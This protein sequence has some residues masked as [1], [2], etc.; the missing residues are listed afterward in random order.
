MLTRACLLL[1]AIASS[2]LA[3]PG[4]PDPTFGT[5]PGFSTNGIAA[6]GNE[7]DVLALALR[8][9]GG[10]VAGGSL[11]TW[12]M[13]APVVAYLSNGAP[14]PS[15]GGGGATWASGA[16]FT[17]SATDDV[18]VQPDGRVLALSRNQ[19]T[20]F[21]ADGTLD[22][23]FGD[24]GSVAIDVQTVRHL[25]ATPD[26]FV[27]AGGTFS[28]PTLQVAR[29]DHDGAPVASFG[30]QG[31]ATIPGFFS[32]GDVVVTPEGTIVVG[33]RTDTGEA[34][35]VRLTALGA[36][37]G[38]FG[39]GGAFVASASSGGV[40]A[41]TLQ[42]DG[43]IVVQVHDTTPPSPTL[44]RLS[45]AGVIDPSY[46]GDGAVE[47]PF[48]AMVMTSDAAGRLLVGGRGTSFPDYGVVARFD[49]DGAL[50]ASFGDG[51]SAIVEDA[52][53]ALVVQPGGRVVAGMVHS[54]RQGFRI[55]GLRG[56][57]RCGDGVVDA[58]ETCDDGNTDDADCCTS[59][60]DVAAAD[61]TTC[62]D[63]SRCITA[64]ACG[65]GVCAGPGCGACGR[66]LPGTG[67]VVAPQPFCL[68]GRGTLVLNDG[69]GARPDGFKWKIDRL[70]P[71]GDVGDPTH[72]T[73]Q[74]LCVYG[75]P[76]TVLLAATVPAGG[77]CGAASCWRVR[78][79]LP[80][81]LALAFAYKDG[82]GNADG[83]QG[84]EYKTGEF[85]WRDSGQVKA[86]GKGP[87]VTVAPFATIVPPVHLQVHGSN[88][89]CYG[90]SFDVL[91]KNDGKTLKATVD[92]RF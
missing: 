92:V 77:T 6:V 41:L 46:G 68:A 21:T 40:A 29:F 53:T 66:C 64:G 52:V 91:K 27:A 19:V 87:N 67:C 48:S 73:A 12:A 88:G 54:D 4:D 31:I 65:A 69:I 61:G 44:I 15:F 22:A 34:V 39:A 5:F 62:S 45:T 11:G 49:A 7:G 58:G 79:S 28:T 8:P 51:G 1:L 71:L 90:T 50:D 26:G 57:A 20:R 74:R 56:D 60:C 76:D 17:A 18:L 30:A 72:D 3:A 47:L 37:D 78:R 16:P 70:R 35:V 59:A 86:N 2:L 81:N 14:D 13:R 9:G 55:A 38:T 89:R 36:M 75:E 10:L 80:G 84:L 32:V 33:L 83:V 43:A 42:S 82:R 24:G 85:D 23:T 25:A 63:A